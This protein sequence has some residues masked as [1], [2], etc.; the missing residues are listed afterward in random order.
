MRRGHSFYDNDNC[1]PY[2]LC[3]G[4][5]AQRNVRTL[6][7]WTLSTVSL[8]IEMCQQVKQR[9]M[10]E[11]EEKYYNKEAVGRQVINVRL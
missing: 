9:Q 4:S 6:T 3:R 8:S 7:V 2:E 10:R 11:E 5:L 1:L